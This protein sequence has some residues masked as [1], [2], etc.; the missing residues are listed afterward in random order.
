MLNYLK[1]D[2]DDKMYTSPESWGADKGTLPMDFPN[3][4][5]IIDGKHAQ[6]E[7][8]AIMEYLASKYNPS[9]I[10][11]TAEEKGKLA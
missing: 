10:G 4:P 9:M 5:Y 3:L 8:I 7:T 6:S 11:K 1:L 2:Y